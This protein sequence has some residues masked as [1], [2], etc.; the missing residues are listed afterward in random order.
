[1]RVVLNKRDECARCARTITQPVTVMYGFNSDDRFDGANGANPIPIL[2]G[3]RNA[4]FWTRYSK[5][6]NIG[7][8][9]ELIIDLREIAKST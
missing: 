7:E 8:P 2:F 6:E 5:A 9:I 1:M 4:V 3:Q